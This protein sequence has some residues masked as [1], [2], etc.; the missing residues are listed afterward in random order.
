MR[1]HGRVDANHAELVAALQRI[2]YLVQSLA[3]I[4]GGCPDVLTFRRDR[5]LELLEFKTTRGTLT[6]AQRRF[7]ALGWPVQLVRSLDEVLR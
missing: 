2:G 4:G 6:P 7:I 5:G 1:K 3:P